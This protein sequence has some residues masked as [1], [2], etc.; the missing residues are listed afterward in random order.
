MPQ[1]GAHVCPPSLNRG[2]G[3][4]RPPYSPQQAVPWAAVIGSTKCLQL[5]VPTKVTAS[6]ARHSF[7]IREP[8]HSRLLETSR[9]T[10]PRSLLIPSFSCTPAVH[11]PIPILTL[12]KGY[13][14]ASASLTSFSLLAF[15]RPIHILTPC[16]RGS[17]RHLKCP[18]TN[19]LQAN[20]LSTPSI[21]LHNRHRWRLK[22]NQIAIPNMMLRSLISQRHP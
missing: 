19:Q 8:A 12:Y 15:A 22:T 18:H 2:G 1:I 13:F 3:N 16:E 4:R 10:H 7:G 11:E 14:P 9:R 17:K 21:H 20:P 5:Q 6:F